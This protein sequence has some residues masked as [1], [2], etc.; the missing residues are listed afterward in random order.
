MFQNCSSPQTLTAQ[1]FPRFHFIFCSKNPDLFQVV[2]GSG[3]AINPY[4][5]RV[6]TCENNFVPIFHYF[7][8]G[9]FFLK[10]F[11]PYSQLSNFG[12]LEQ[13]AENPWG[14][15]D[16]AVPVFGTILILF[17]LFH[18]GIAEQYGHMF[19]DRWCVNMAFTSPR[20]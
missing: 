13:K 15:R 7:P 20:N 4:V 12:T 18:V 17:Q 14:T 3:T 11:F 16:S 5:S 1:G 9:I 19:Y 10:L 6:F 2:P 8:I